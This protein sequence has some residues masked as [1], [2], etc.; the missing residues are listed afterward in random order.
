MIQKMKW[1]ALVAVSAAA[2]SATAV[3]KDAAPGK[4][5][6][7]DLFPDKVVAKGK[8][9]EVK[10]S[11]LEEAFIAYKATLAAR[12]VT[13]PEDKRQQAEADLLNQLVIEKLLMQRATDADKKKGAENEEKTM[14]DIKKQMPDEVF[15]QRIKAAGMTEERVRERL[16]SDAIQR[17]VVDRELKSK[18]TVSDA[19]VKKYYDE[20]SARFEKPEQVRASHILIS[21]VD[22]DTQ[23]SLP[24]AKKK[25]KQD[26]A[27]KLKERAEKGEDFAKL[28]KEFSEDPGS[29]DQG[30][31][32]T[33]GKGEMVPAFETAAFSLKPNQVSDIVETQYGYHIIKL[34]EKIPAHKEPLDKVSSDIREML[35]Q[36][37]VS[38]Q[39]PAYFDKLKSDAG[40]E[41]VG[42]KKA[43]AVK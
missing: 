22:K 7:K 14:A 15:K 36:R 2:F 3:Q 8:N 12:G 27:K 17:S 16:R 20:N 1:A 9:V 41:I 32:Y 33:F 19:D 37:E 34:S 23:K 18:I 38:K 11:E 29:K 35:V 28:A 31:E 10:Q 39:L 4:V 42:E 26:L 24:E 30:G 40:V 25:E 13:L 5:S 43:A 21:T 6:D